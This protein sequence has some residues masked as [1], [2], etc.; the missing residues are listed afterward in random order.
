MDFLEI[1]RE[2]NM[3]QP[4]YE[5]IKDDNVSQLWSILISGAK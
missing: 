1:L 3:I 5:P 2:L 4:N